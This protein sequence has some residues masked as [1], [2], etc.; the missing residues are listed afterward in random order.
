M[1]QDLVK[2]SVEAVLGEPI[3]AD[4]PLMA[5]GLDSVGALELQQSLAV[6]LGLNRLPTTLVFDH[7]TIAALATHL[8]AIAMDGAANAA[9]VLDSMA[10][11][12]QRQRHAAA[13]IVSMSG[14][15][16]CSKVHMQLST[17]YRKFTV[18][19]AFYRILLI[20]T[21]V[22]VSASA[23]RESAIWRSAGKAQLSLGWESLAAGHETVLQH[24][25]VGDATSVV[26]WARWDVEATV[27]GKRSARPRFG[28]FLPTERVAG[29]DC[30][31]LG[32]SPG[33]ARTVDPQ[34][35]L[36]LQVGRAV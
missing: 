28:A 7:P 13:E 14:A 31:A 10:T 6:T 20:A 1:L 30:V 26:P 15:S 27:Q 19:T 2:R 11:G 3:A 34:Q 25:T 29:T 33:E 9:V 24:W 8:H 16:V 12:P 36:L 5:A 21:H 32:L 23:T 4:Q 22:L 17:S 18:F 35:R